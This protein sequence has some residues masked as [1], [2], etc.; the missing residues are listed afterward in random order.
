MR[1]VTLATLWPGLL[2]LCLAGPAAAQWPPERLENLKFFPA[3]IPVR[4]LIDTMAGFTRALGVRC[5]HCH[6]GQEGQPLETYDFASDEKAAKLKAREMLRMVAAIN[7]EHL[8]KLTDRREPPI[9]VTCTTCHRGVTEPRPLQQVLLTAY[10]AAGA[11]SAEAAYR[12][13]RA[14]YYGRAA[15]DFGEV[16]LTNM[17]SALRARGRVAD[18]VRFYVLNTEFSPASA[19]AHWQAAEG[20]LAAGDTAAAVASLERTLAINATH[21]EAKRRLEALRRT[22]RR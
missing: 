12:A 9:T 20:H 7:G 14:R 16:P 1:R 18:A 8:A 11:D 22:P 19:F 4:A 6:V 13:L 2:S 17:A 15:Y 3:D 21:Q 5:T 10:D